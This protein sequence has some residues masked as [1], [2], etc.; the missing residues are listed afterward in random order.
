[1]TPAKGR[2][3][4]AGK[5]LYSPRDIAIGSWMASH[6]IA[7]AHVPFHRD[8]RGLASTDQQPTHCTV[9]NLWG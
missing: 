1:V 9:E 8:N 3:E 4:I 6:Y 5:L 7:D 2:A